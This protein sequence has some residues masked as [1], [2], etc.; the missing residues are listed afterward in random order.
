MNGAL[1]EPAL[2]SLGQPEP[3]EDSPLTWFGELMLAIERGDPRRT[4][5]AHEQLR[6]L[7]WWVAP[8][9]AGVRKGVK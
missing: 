2:P 6:R 4:A 7:G 9:K 5:E 1:R 8:F 3:A